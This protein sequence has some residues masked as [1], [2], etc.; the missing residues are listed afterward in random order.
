MKNK[1]FRRSIS[2]ALALVFGFALYGC[3]GGGSSNSTPTV[4]GVAASGAAMSGQVFLKDSNNTEMSRTMTSNDQGAFS[5]DV[6]GK[7]APFMLRSGSLYSM[8]G[9]PGTANINPLSNLMVADMGGFSN[10]SSL[11]TFYRN[12]NSATMHSM[13][14]N[15]SNARL[16]LR[17]KMTP[18][19][20]T[21]GVP[22]ADPIS[23]AFTI[24]Q[25]MDRM[26]DD[27]KMTI[28]ANGNVSMMYVSG[29]PVFTGQMG[30]MM[31][32]NMMSGSI[33]TP[34]ANPVVSGITITPGI[35]KLP[36]GG[37]QQFSVT[38]SIPVIWSVN[39]GSIAVDGMYTAT[40]QGMFLVRATSVA[41][42]TQS[43]TTT[44][45]VGSRGMMM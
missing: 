20:T 6:S 30:N 17:Q 12:P 11:N 43:T 19:L 38:P 37:T 7:T 16:H 41:D 1:T 27:V 26:F 3:G 14:G 10:M 18:L 2:L 21:Y 25:G 36:V 35:A 22:N 23:G 39:G 13:F 15:M 45:Q 40:V 42:P 4:S 31:G 8:S 44:I 5:F 28:D 33:V 24:G 32:G 34:P 9:G 29:T